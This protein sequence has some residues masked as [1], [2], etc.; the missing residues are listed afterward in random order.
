MNINKTL[1][2]TVF[3]G[4]IGFATASSVFG[5]PGSK[6]VPLFNCSEEAFKK[7]S[8]PL[9]KERAEKLKALGYDN[10]FRVVSF[11]SICNGLGKK[12]DDFAGDIKEDEKTLVTF[13]K[14]IPCSF[15]VDGCD[16]S[17]LFE[18]GHFEEYKRHLLAALLVYEFSE[19]RKQVLAL[20]RFLLKDGILFD[21]TGGLSVVGGSCHM[22]EK[23]NSPRV[24]SL[25]TS[26]IFNECVASA[27]FHE[28]N[29]VLHLHLSLA[30]EPALCSY[31]TKFIRDVYQITS[32]VDSPVSLTDRTVS[33]IYGQCPEIALDWDVIEE[34]WNILG[35][36]EINGTVY[37]NEF[38]DCAL[39]YD[40]K[41]LEDAKT[42]SLPYHQPTVMMPYIFQKKEKWDA[43]VC[44]QGYMISK[45]FR[46]GDWKDLDARDKDN[47]EGSHYLEAISIALN[48][49]PLS[50]GDQ[51]SARCDVRDYVK[52]MKACADNYERLKQ[53]DVLSEK[54]GSAGSSFEA[55]K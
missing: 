25:H 34:A 19:K 24:I 7:Y 33:E 15:H 50:N 30:G 52:F 49:P 16:V 3:F 55:S 14:H 8:K 13:I 39:P 32:K 20:C 26:L 48:I 40:T 44:R 38:S 12:P 27:L 2:N 29:H 47:A 5:D 41:P 10:E 4:C 6:Q 43:Y 9:D 21:F 28:L 1:K 42:T 46:L 51:A 18:P 37:I 23:D 22:E 53:A 45:D 36:I 54:H 35:F 11:D 31:T 17:S